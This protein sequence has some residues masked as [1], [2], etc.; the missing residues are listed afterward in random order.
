[1]YGIINKEVEGLTNEEMAS[2]KA[3]KS[4]LSGI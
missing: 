1:V 3:A 4:S 2:A